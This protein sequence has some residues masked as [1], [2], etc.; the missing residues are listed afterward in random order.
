MTYSRENKHQGRYSFE[1]RSSQYEGRQ[2][3][4]STFKGRTMVKKNDSQDYNDK[5]EDDSRR[6]QYTQGD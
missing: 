4:C 1:K 3:E 5:K 2:Q 6:K